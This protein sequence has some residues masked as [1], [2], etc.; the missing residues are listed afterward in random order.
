[1]NNVSTV[2][3]VANRCSRNESVRSPSERV[4]ERGIED[5]PT[6]KIDLCV[7][8][9]MRVKPF[10]KLRTRCQSLIIYIDWSDCFVSSD[11][12]LIY[13]CGFSFFSARLYD[14]SFN[15]APSFLSSNEIQQDL[16]SIIPEKK[17]DEPEVHKGKENSGAP[18]NNIT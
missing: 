17:G 13:K 11:I 8:H 16:Y 9:Q 1:M 14:R 12:F 15:V 5:V 6:G 3:I 10:A 4:G 2:S 18:V 7:L